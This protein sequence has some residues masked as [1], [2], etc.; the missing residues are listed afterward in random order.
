[1]EKQ[2]KDSLNFIL[3]AVATVKV[4]AETA[5]TKLNTEFQSLAAKG[6]QDQSE[7]SVTL[8]K[9]LQ[10][11]ISQLEVLVGKANTAVAEAK[12]KVATATS[13]A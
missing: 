1:M 2:V 3:G 4:E 10:D 6:A 11:G 13:K 9:Y 8:R 5:W 7:T 12:Q